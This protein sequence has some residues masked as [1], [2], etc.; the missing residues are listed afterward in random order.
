MAARRFGDREDR[1][2]ANDDRMRIPPGGR[3]DRSRGTGGDFESDWAGREL[4]ERYLTGGDDL[5]VK[6]DPDWTRYMMANPQLT[7]QLNELVQ[8]RA[9]DAFE[10]RGTSRQPGPEHFD[11]KGRM[12]IQNG[13]S[14]SGW[15]YLHGTDKDAGGF[16]FRGSTEVTRV[17]GGYEVHVPATYTWNDKIDPN[18][19]YR[20]D[21]I[22]STI[23]EVITL[24]RADGYE[25]HLSWSGDATVRLD[26][27]GN[28]LWVRGY[29]GD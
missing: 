14:I 6:D 16:K 24:S 20:S 28:V 9:I 10:R 17:D 18:P 11:D 3:T 26:E 8:N 2:I 5:T 1:R 15:Q 19:E 13:E 27:D 22:K 29:P 4:L 25:L 12:E 21:Q 23:A 7:R